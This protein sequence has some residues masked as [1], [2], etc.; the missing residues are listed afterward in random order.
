MCVGDMRTSPA[1][2]DDALAYIDQF[3]AGIPK[4]QIHYLESGVFVTRATI[5]R[6]RGRDARRWTTPSA[7]LK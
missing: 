3:R 5:M 2:W 7:R 4:G 1:D 6:G